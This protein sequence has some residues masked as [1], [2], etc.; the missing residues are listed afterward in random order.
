MSL[1][2]TYLLTEGQQCPM[3]QQ[4]FQSTTLHAWRDAFDKNRI[5]FAKTWAG[6]TLQPFQ[7]DTSMA[8][9]CQKPQRLKH[10]G[11]ATYNRVQHAYAQVNGQNL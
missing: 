4:T 3:Y 6:Q 7:S 5:P 2:P 8:F 1:A 10:F 9:F 11:A